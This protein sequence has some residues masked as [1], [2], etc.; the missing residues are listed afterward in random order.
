M[1]LGR[2]SPKRDGQSDDMDKMSERLRTTVGT[3]YLTARNMSASCRRPWLTICGDQCQ[4]QLIMDCTSVGAVT[5]SEV[6]QG[7]C[8]VARV[9]RVAFL[10]LGAQN[11]SRVQGTRQ[12][13]GVSS[14]A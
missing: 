7:R 4:V 12:D 8:L 6:S 2:R 5:C 13:V 10:L 3:V 1:F 11:R 9:T 14:T